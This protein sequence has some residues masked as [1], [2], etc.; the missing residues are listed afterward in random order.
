MS[1]LGGIQNFGSL[2]GSFAQNVADNPYLQ[3]RSS[4]YSPAQASQFKAQVMEQRRQEEERQKREQVLESLKDKLPPE[5]IDMYRAGMLDPSTLG[6]MLG[7]GRNQAN[8]GLTPMYAR[9]AEGKLTAYQLNNQGG[10]QALDLPEGMQPFVGYDRSY[11]EARG[12]GDA[13]IETDPIAAGLSE[14]QKLAQRLQYQ[15]TIAAST[16]AATNEA[17]AATIPSVKIAEAAGAKRGQEI[18]DAPGQIIKAE[19][20]LSIIDQALQHPGL[21]DAVG[22]SSVLNPLASTVLSGTD[23]AGYL[24][25]QKQMEGKAFWEAFESLK[26]YGQITEVEGIKATQALAR[27]DTAQ[28]ETDYRAALNELRG[29]ISMGLDRSRTKIGQPAAAQEALGAPGAATPK[30]L[31]YNPQTGAFE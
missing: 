11:S 1:L 14:Q 17:N 31:R 8:Y 9:D 13:K 18:A 30:R 19:A 7:A 2:L 3:G 21:K 29:Y 28:N 27:L 12:R 6:A 15:P 23:R 24:A 4:G 20:A 5:M 22:R 25:L 26:G 10:L 16:T